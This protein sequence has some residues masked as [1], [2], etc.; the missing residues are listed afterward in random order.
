M[1]VCVCNNV[2]E[3]KL[4]HAV[5]SGLNTMADL[6]THLEVGTCCGKCAGCARRILRECQTTNQIPHHANAMAS[7]TPIIFQR[8]PITPAFQDDALAA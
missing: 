7:V 8:P 3:K 6:R 5:A 1:I 2:S 4:R